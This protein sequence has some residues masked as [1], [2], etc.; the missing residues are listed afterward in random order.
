MD[1][2]TIGEKFGNKKAVLI[3]YLNIPCCVVRKEG[4]A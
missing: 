1:K 3:A 4:Y 2:R